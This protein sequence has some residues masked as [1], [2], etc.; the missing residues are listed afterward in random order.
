MTEMEIT[1]RM[2]DIIAEYSQLKEIAYFELSLSPY[3]NKLNEVAGITVT[4]SNPGKT[5]IKERDIQNNESLDFIG[6]TF[7]YPSTISSQSKPFHA[8]SVKSAY[9]ADDGTLMV[10]HKDSTERFTF[11]KNMSREDVLKKVYNK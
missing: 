4:L 10:V 8:E 11:A 3:Y 5:F 9:F 6:E 1:Q 7:H 2:D